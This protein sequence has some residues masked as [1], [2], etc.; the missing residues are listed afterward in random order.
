MVN[1]CETM[2]GAAAESRTEIVTV[3][4]AALVSVPV[5]MPAAERVSPAGSVPVVMDHEYGCVPPVALSA[6]LTVFASVTARVEPVVMRSGSVTVTANELVAV[7]PVASVTR[8]EK[9]YEPIA[10]GLPESVPPPARVR[11]GGSW[12][13]PRVHV[14]GVV[15]PSARILRN[16]ARYA[17]LL[18][19]WC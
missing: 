4:V 14:Y 19:A 1:T 3:A 10:L 15:P 12:P 16:K 18:E 11:P 2:A 17:L 13:S 9:R 7:W 5:M 6:I 8:M